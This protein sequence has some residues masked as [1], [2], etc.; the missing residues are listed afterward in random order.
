[1]RRLKAEIKE[2]MADKN[3]EQE[4]QEKQTITRLYSMVEELQQKI[5]KLEKG[6]QLA[7]DDK[8]EYAT[9]QTKVFIRE[10]ENA[11]EI[12]SKK[13]KELMDMLIQQRE[14]LSS[15]LEKPVL[16]DSLAQRNHQ[17]EL[18]TQKLESR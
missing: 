15:V 3:R 18:E 6:K 14:K 1:M 11:N 4:K 7:Q 16:K 8:L 10:L 2:L 12:I 9:Y 13:N 5:I 17:Y